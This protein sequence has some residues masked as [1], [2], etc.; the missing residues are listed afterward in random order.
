MNTRLYTWVITTIL[1]IFMSVGLSSCKHHDEPDP[2]PKTVSR[3]ILVY[4]VANNNLG[5]RGYDTQD[6]NEMLTAARSGGLHNGRL[7]VY[8][9]PYC[10]TPALK[11]IT[12]EGIVTRLEYGTDLPSV[13]AARMSQVI[14]DAKALAPA[15][16]YGIVLWSHATGWLQTGIEETIQPKTTDGIRPL[17]YGDDNGQTMR[18]TTLAKVLDGKNFSFVYCD[19]CHMASVE[20]AYELRYATDYIVGSVTELPAA[21]MRYDLNIPVLLRDGDPDLNQAAKNTYEHYSSLSLMENRTCT[22]SVIATAALDELA[23]ATRDIYASGADL[24]TA[25]E[26]QPFE[27]SD[28]CHYF[29]LA[30]YVLSYDT[31]H[32]LKE[33][34]NAAIDR[35][36][37]YKANTPYIWALLQ[38]RT[39]CG[40]STY[41]LTDPSKASESGYSE[42]QWYNDVASY[43]DPN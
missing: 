8:H 23:A 24:S 15:G 32:A 14:D 27:I 38:I 13:S 2:A 18:I 19:C 25:Y 42:L 22:M 37:M 20:V 17:D 41:P 28:N 16:D 21:G 33:R 3:T 5:S 29:D 43:I 34:W 31:D 4:M 26:P 40:L 9:A 35:T 1:M 36:V 12:P 6:L 10:Q 11:E 39:H 30:N 7:L